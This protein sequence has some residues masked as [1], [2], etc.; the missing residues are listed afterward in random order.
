MGQG[1][2]RS[3]HGSEWPWLGMAGHGDFME[4]ARQEITVLLRKIG[5]VDGYQGSG[6]Q[7]QTFTAG[8]CC[9]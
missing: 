9:S 3:G 7:A 8:L 2:I 4:T 1:H 5:R 6:W